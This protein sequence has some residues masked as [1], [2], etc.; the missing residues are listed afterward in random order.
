[1]RSAT[2]DLAYV[3]LLNAIDQVIATPVDSHTHEEGEWGA[4][5][6]LAHLIAVDAGILAVTSLIA[7]GSRAAY[8]NRLTLDTHNLKHISQRT[9][10]LT[11]MRDR[12]QA[13]GRALC[14]VV[15]HLTEQELSQA[16]PTLLVSG[17][18]TLV[19][20][21]ISLEDLLNG[22]SGDHLPRHT[23]QLLRLLPS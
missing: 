21:T 10:S 15:E 11:Q 6:Q 18:T 4:E 13:Q 22:I 3:H 20:Q 5:Q 8:D 17:S 2:F 9:G 23:Q 12:V 16:V 1:M 14:Q 7:T 19:D